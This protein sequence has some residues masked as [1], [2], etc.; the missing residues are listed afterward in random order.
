[1]PAGMTC[2]ARATR[3][4][5]DYESSPWT[6]LLCARQ[7]RT[8]LRLGCFAA[9]RTIVEPSIV[10]EKLA[11]ALQASLLMRHGEIALG[12]A[13]CESRFGG[14]HGHVFGT[15]STSV[16]VKSIIEHNRPAIG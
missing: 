7:N 14:A 8:S 5:G 11:I 3:N 15:L 12:D 9:R 6:G 13:F 4:A 16:D 10:A 1:M 2:L